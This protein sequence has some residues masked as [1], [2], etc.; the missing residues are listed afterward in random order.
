MITGEY[1]RHLKG[2]TKGL[3]CFVCAPKEPTVLYPETVVSE[4]GFQETLPQLAGPV[5]A[6]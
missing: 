2:M 3:G 5:P 1:I 6:Y 4:V